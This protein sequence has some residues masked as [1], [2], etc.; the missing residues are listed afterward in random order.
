MKTFQYLCIVSFFTSTK[1]SQSSIPTE[2]NS[3]NKGSSS[4]KVAPPKIR[5]SPLLRIL[6][7]VRDQ[8][9]V[10]FGSP[11]LGQ[12]FASKS[13]FLAR[14]SAVVAQVVT[15]LAWNPKKGTGSN[16]ARAVRAADVV[17]FWTT[18][19]KDLSSNSA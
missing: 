1:T 5:K 11:G 10:F 18:G 15:F 12:V 6:S 19:S 13:N 2:K 14:S 16:P 8:L 3:P 7:D 17:K 9:F 4:V